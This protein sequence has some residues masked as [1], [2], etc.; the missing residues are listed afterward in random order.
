MRRMA[1]VLM[2]RRHF[3]GLQEWGLATSLHQASR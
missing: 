1:I 3:K 2:L